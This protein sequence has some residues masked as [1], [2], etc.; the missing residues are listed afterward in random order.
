M[1]YFLPNQWF[2][3]AQGKTCQV[4]KLATRARG[5]GVQQVR[6]PSAFGGTSWASHKPVPALQ[7]RKHAQSYWCGHRIQP[8][9][10]QWIPSQTIVA[11]QRPASPWQNTDIFSLSPLPWILSFDW[12]LALRGDIAYIQGRCDLP[13]AQSSILQTM[14][15]TWPFCHPTNASSS[16]LTRGN[17]GFTK[18]KY[19]SNG[20]AVFCSP[21]SSS[22]G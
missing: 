19:C 18:W 15:S 11:H 17:K 9:I 14:T 21:S 7:V 16:G 20:F 1:E 22:I 4:A 5:G 8:F 12:L 2:A 3:S 6:E 10:S 13:N